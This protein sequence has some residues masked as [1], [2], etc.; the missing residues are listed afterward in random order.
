MTEQ[1]TG[2]GLLPDRPG[3]AMSMASPPSASPAPAGARGRGSILLGVAI[4]WATFV[5]AAFSFMYAFTSDALAGPL[6]SLAVLMP[7]ALLVGGIVLAIVPKTRRTGAGV[8]IG[9]GSGALFVG[10]WLVVQIVANSL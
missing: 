10:G 5:G 1:P 2:P 7:V 8:L 6:S 9:I 3:P 4:A